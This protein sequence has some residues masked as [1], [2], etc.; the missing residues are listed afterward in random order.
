MIRV[1]ALTGWGGGPS[2]FEVEGDASLIGPEDGGSPDLDEIDVVI[3][4]LH[5]ATSP[6]ETEAEAAPARVGMKITWVEP[7]VA[8]SVPQ[9]RA[10]RDAIDHEIGGS[11]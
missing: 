2:W 9:A 6:E 11:S 4:R 8:L 1:E 5:A 10:L 7:T 3:V